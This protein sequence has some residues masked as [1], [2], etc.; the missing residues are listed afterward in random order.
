MKARKYLLSGIFWKKTKKGGLGKD[1]VANYDFFATNLIFR[2][3]LDLF[4][5]AKSLILLVG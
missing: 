4:L 3:V 1:L 5:G 2:N